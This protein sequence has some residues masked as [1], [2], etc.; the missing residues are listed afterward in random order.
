MNTDAPG[1]TV[2]QRLSLKDQLC[3]VQYVG[4]VGDKPG[5]WLGVEWDDPARGKHDGTHQ[6]VLYFKCLHA[7]KDRI[8]SNSADQHYRPV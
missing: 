3:T 8:R 6:G 7:V 4:P 1:Y 5:S 2:G